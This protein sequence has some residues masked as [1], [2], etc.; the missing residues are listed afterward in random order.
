MAIRV[1]PPPQV[2]IPDKFFNDPEIRSFLERWQTILFQLWNRTG[3]DLDLVAGQQIIVTTS[4]NLTVADFST[5]V[6]VEADSAE[7][8]ITLPVITDSVVGET[9][10]V[11][12]TD[13]TFDTHVFPQGGATIMDDSSVLM[14]QK[15]MS[16]PFT[17]ITKTNWYIAS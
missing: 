10:E 13:A 17:A 8:N 3:G 12:I 9:V 11:L 1:N 6:V 2:R 16:L 4:S 14:N 15:Y 7:V 5:L